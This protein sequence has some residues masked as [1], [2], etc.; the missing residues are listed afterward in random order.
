[1]ASNAMASAIHSGLS[2]GQQLTHL[3]RA[4]GEQQDEA[5]N[6]ENSDDLEGAPREP[7]G[8]ELL[9]HRHGPVDCAPLLQSLRV[10]QP[11]QFPQAS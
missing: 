1:M 9:G 5:G 7:A 11:V 2:L 6:D 8:L 3:R 4:R 10:S